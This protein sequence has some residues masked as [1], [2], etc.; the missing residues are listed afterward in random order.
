MIRSSPASL[1]DQAIKAKK[2]KDNRLA[3][4]G[5]NV[6]AERAILFLF[7]NVAFF[8]R[9]NAEPFLFQRILEK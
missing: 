1:Y 2:K 6:N 5:Q 4:K 8:F 3:S 7:Y 9:S